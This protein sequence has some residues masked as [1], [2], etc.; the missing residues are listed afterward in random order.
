MATV[1]R[2]SRV[3]ID[4]IQIWG[5]IAKDD[6]LAADRQLDRIDAAC[7]ML[8]ENPQ[9][10]PRREDLA[11]GLRFYPVGNYLIFYTA[12]EDGINL[13]RVLHGARD[14]PREFQ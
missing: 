6:P 11:P 5:H 14:Y 9:G 7:K 3:E 13:A 12:G 4:L 2:S 1:H 10:G 8:A